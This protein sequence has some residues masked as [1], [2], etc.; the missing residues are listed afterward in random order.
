[1]K[2]TQLPVYQQKEKIIDVLSHNQVVVVESPTGS[3][4]T[5]Q[6]PIILHE[7][8]FGKNGIIG[9]TQPRRIAAVSVCDYIANQFGV[10]IPNTVGYKM[11]FEDITDETTQ[12]KIMTDGTLLQEIKSDTMLSRYSCIIVDEAHER[13][14]NIDFILG[15]L[16]KVLAARPEFKVV[17]SSA[18]INAQVFS[19]YF[20][21]CPVVHIE[22]EMYPVQVIYDPPPPEGGPDAM[23]M[24]IV[25]IVDR[26]IDQYGRGDLLIFLS[27]EKAIKDCVSMLHALPYRKKLIILPLY[28]R[29]SKEEQER[30]FIPTPQGKHKI[31]VATNIA[32]TSVTIDGITAVIDSGLAKR[33]YYNPRTFTSS[34]IENPIS[35]AS[36][37]QRKGRAG[38][39]QP[40]TCYRL[41]NKDD[42]KNRPLFEMEEIY[43][44]DLS[45]VV[46]RMAEIGIKDFESFD[47]ISSPG[48]QGIIGA[49]ESLNY[50][51][52]LTSSRELSETGAMMAKFPL[53]PRLSRIIVEAVKSYPQTIDETLI[54]TSFLST[55]T[56]FLLP[57]GEEIAARK[58]HHKFSDP[59]GDFISYIKLLRAYTKSKKKE[60]FCETYYLDSKTMSE[61]ANIKMQL[62]DI[63][64]EMKIPILSGGPVSDYLCAVSRGLIQFVCLRTGRFSYSSLTAD[65]IQIHPGSV[66]FRETPQY[67]VAG[68]IIRTSK[69]FARSVSP[70][71]KEWL[72]QISPILADSF[73]K[74]S[75]SKKT[76]AQRQTRREE[77][78]E[79]KIKLGNKIFELIP[80]KNKKKIV[81]LPWEKLL[82]VLEFH[83]P[84]AFSEYKQMRGKIL[85]DG[86]EILTGERLASIFKIAPWIDTSAGIVK[87]TQTKKNY[88]TPE[89][90]EPLC[91]RLQNILKLCTSKKK[92]QLGFIGLY[93]DGIG[94]YWFKCSRGFHNALSQS[95]ASLEILADE[96]EESTYKAHRDTVNGIYRKLSEYFEK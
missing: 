37:N 33:N 20:N 35:K 93:T 29:L 83:E 36:C 89:E 27:G 79:N 59:Y 44:T 16:K 84:A 15:L 90:V 96:L 4:K 60:E 77:Q 69:I 94:H 10:T 62:G 73:L 86:Y 2:P 61:L 81:V 92:K 46:L 70:L 76:R 66:M 3:G 9:I 18:T 5:T 25:E 30:V 78:I 65:K 87:N 13:S 23:L 64:T 55:N 32:E 7:S 63:L 41:Y 28:S 19:E 50:L 47:F 67:I 14:L 53:L 51:D 24:K 95:L 88:A 31:V 40:G 45:E 43:R 71:K 48:R 80:Y 68:E 54:A 8:E 1:M 57:Q 72:R 42:Y 74:S 49:I 39:T 17:I 6:L 34:L 58:A 82:S 26:Y 22:S 12:I 38:R 11:R 21:S 75:K 91:N 85:Y 52:A 56:P